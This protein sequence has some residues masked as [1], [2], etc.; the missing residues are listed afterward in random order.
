[1]RK[2][3]IRHQVHTH[4]RK[5]KIVRNYVRGAG[6]G[7]ILANPTINP[8]TTQSLLPIEKLRLLRKLGFNE[9]TKDT[10]KDLPFEQL[11]KDVKTA[12]LTEK[13][14]EHQIIEKFKDDPAK[15]Q[16]EL[17]FDHAK[18]IID[19]GKYQAGPNDR[20]THESDVAWNVAVSNC[21]FQYTRLEPFSRELDL[22][23][24][25][26][27]KTDDYAKQIQEKRKVKGN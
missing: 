2:T 22:T 27:Q 3:P 26:I 20:T 10:A 6:H 25:Y 19:S 13:A 18:R 17:V 1:M 24:E 11:P 9:W 7:T 21:R 4:R 15:M 5:G 23:E 8:N 16:A 12:L 14:R